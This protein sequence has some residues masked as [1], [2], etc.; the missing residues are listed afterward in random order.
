MIIKRDVMCAAGV[1]QVCAGHSVGCEAAIHVLRQ[2]FEA[3]GTDGVLLVD[4]ENAFNRLNRAVTLHNI[5]YTCPLLATTAI[6][7][8]RSPTR[9]FVTGGM[10]LSSEEGTVQ[11][12]PL[13]MAVYALSVVPLINTCRDTASE[14]CLSAPKIY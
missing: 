10:E 2:M 12:C 4:A 11:G 3:V 9:L 7:F 6:N 14:G 5:Q 1:V 13:S 8:Y